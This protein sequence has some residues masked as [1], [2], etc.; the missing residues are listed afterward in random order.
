MSNEVNSNELLSLCKRRGFIWPSFELYGGV[1]GM[2]D[3]GPLGSNMRNNILE[4]W[5]DIYRGRE[6]FIEIDSETVNPREVFKA[7]GHVDEFADLITYCTK[8]ESAFR[9]D[10]LVKEF[11]DN[12]DVLSPKQLDEAFVKFDVKCP[13]CGEKLGPV[14]EF[15]L[16][17]KTTIGPGSSR[18]GYLRP[19]TAQGIFVNYLNLYRYNREKLPLGVIQTGRGYRN[20]IAPRQGMIRMREFNMMEVELFV[21]PDD[22]NWSR[23]PDIENDMIV[24][25]PNTGTETV[26]MT[27]GEAVRK[28]IIANKVLAYFVYTTQQFLVRLGVDPK[29]LRFRQHLRDEMAHYAKDCW[30]AEI[31]LSFGW[32]EVT[33]IADRGCW[34]LSRHAEFSGTEL[35]HFKKFDEPKEIEIDKVKAKH[36]ALGPKFKG[37]AKDIAEMMETK[38]PSDIKDGKLTLKVEGEEIVLDG[39]FFEVVKVCEKVSGERVVPH[40][41]EPSHGLDRI[42]YSVLEHSYSYDKKEDYTVLRLAPEVAP[43]KIGIFPL[44]EKDGLD[45]LALDIYKK[46]HSTST[47]AYYDGSGTIGKRYARMDEVGTPWCVTVDYESLDGPSKGTV[48]IRDRDTTAQKRISADSVQETLRSLLSGKRFEDL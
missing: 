32:I 13:E 9:A 38:H 17:F 20:E 21:D 43:I 2:F 1:A 33:G 25:V 34:D 28:G 5:R 37:K 48:T 41:I 45:T 39:E 30:D 7:S 35:T 29:R 11:F 27:V 31:L 6:G 44:M 16:M 46:V 19:E 8:C 12:A 14:E 42:F 26:T 36:K 47:E 18:V 24:L 4:V 23:F 22:K 15:N 40:V 3:Y 10:H